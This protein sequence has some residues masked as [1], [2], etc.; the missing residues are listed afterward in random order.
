MVAYL[1]T[2]NVG[3]EH[4][5]FC[6]FHELISFKEHALMSLHISLFESHR[7]ARAV[8]PQYTHKYFEGRVQ[9]HEYARTGRCDKSDHG[10]E[11]NV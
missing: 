9:L 8:R 2:A 7:F 1:V 10:P 6:L 5:I 4:F 11:G 3:K